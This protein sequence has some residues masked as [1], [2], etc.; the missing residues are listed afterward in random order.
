MLQPHALRCTKH[1][2]AQFVHQILP[3]SVVESSYE[4]RAQCAAS[5]GSQHGRTEYSQQARIA[6]WQCRV[7]QSLQEDRTCHVNCYYGEYES[8][9]INESASV[10]IQQFQYAQPQRAIA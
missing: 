4:H 1:V 7:Y 3:D 8:D 5:C 2:G 10:E 6:V 9:G